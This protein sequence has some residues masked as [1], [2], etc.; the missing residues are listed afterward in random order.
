[1]SDD[2]IK[3]GNGPQDGND[4][5]NADFD[6]A[7]GFNDD[8]GTNEPRGFKDLMQASPI[9]KIGIVFGVIILVVGAIVLFGGEE[10]TEITSKVRQGSSVDDAPGADN[11]TQSYEE[12][13]NEFNINAVEEA[14]KQGNSALPVPVGSTRGRLEQEAAAPPAEDP[15]DRWRRIQ[16]ERQKR[17][18]ASRPK[19]PTVDPNAEAIDALSKAMAGQMESV[20]SSKKIASIEIMGVTD[21]SWLEQKEEAERSAAAARRAETDADA[22][23]AAEPERILVPAGEVEYAQLLIEANSDA[24]GPVLAQ[25]ASGPLAGSR[26]LG[27]FQVQ[28]EY[29]VLTFNQVVIDGVSQSMSGIALDP[30]TT[31]IG[32][33]T[34]IDHRYFSRIILPAAA[35]FV[36]GMAGAI[37]DTG[38]SVTVTGDAA[39]EETPEPDATEELYAGME[40]A[41]GQ[42][43][44]ILDEDADDKKPQIKVRAGTPIGILLLEPVMEPE[45]EAIVVK[46]DKPY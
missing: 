15:L 23:A 27:T 14:L 25:I 30:A 1:M 38:T 34:D 43:S 6:D 28:E 24:P 45:D 4:I 9:I 16:E 29:L 26:I 20:L 35:K 42:I 18:T 19:M 7:G 39:V 36:E 44:D 31:G 5:D 21:P 3:A 17:T 41:A 8:F 2:I 46:N 10:Q 32:I 33:V 40:E 13:V 11:I 12:A 37:A 22:A